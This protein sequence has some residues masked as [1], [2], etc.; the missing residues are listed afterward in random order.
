MAF[1]ETFCGIQ[2]LVPSGQ[3]SSIL[4]A[5]VKEL[6]V[7]MYPLATGEYTLV[8]KCIFQ[9]LLIVLQLKYQLYQVL[10]LFKSD[11]LCIQ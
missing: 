6:G 7:N 10:K 9:I 5:L 1:G 4:P 8:Y 3:D 11:D 2:G